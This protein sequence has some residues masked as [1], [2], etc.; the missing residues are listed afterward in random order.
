MQFHMKSNKHR[1]PDGF[2]SNLWNFNIIQQRENIASVPSNKKVSLWKACSQSIRI[3]T[4]NISLNIWRM[5]LTYPKTA[6][7]CYSESHCKPVAKVEVSRLW[8][9]HPI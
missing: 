1:S 5:I 3:L 7:N 6:S 2:I 4:Y 8:K 9:K